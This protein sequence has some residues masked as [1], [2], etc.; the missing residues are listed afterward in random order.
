MDAVTQNQSQ[1]ESLINWLEERAAEPTQ[2]AQKEEPAYVFLQGDELAQTR[3]SHRALLMRAKALAA[4]LQREFSAGDRAIL[5]Y[6]SGLD[7]IVAFFA[8]L[9]AGVIAVPAFPPNARKRDWGRIDAIF[10]NANPAL[11]LTSLC[12]Q[13]GIL[14]W[15]QDQCREK[16]VPVLATDNIDE[17]LVNAWQ[18]PDLNGNSVAFL[19]YS[20]GSTGTPKGVMVSHNNIRHNMKVIHQGFAVNE[21]ERIAS[22]LPIYHDMGLIGS[23]I[24][25]LDVRSSVFFMAPIDALQQ[26][27]RWL[28]VIS[29]F[30]ITASGGP[31]FIYQ[32]CVE[33]VT[34]EQKAQLD[35]SQW[36]LAYNGA[37]PVSH[38]TLQ[39]FA[40]AFAGCGFQVQALTP[41]YGM[42]ETTLMVSS[43][44]RARH[45]QV[46]V[47][48]WSSPEAN[49]TTKADV[50]AALNS[51]EH[52]PALLYSVSSG[53]PN[54][55]LE[56]KI[57]DPD[58]CMECE[59]GQ[60]G[61][62]WVRG[63]SVALG[64]WGQDALTQE[65]FH[66][67]IM[68]QPEDYL[69]TGDLGFMQQGELFVTGR[70]KEVIIIR[71]QNHY[72]QDIEATVA[73]CHDVF[74]GCY[75]AAFSVEVDGAEK[76]VITH[77]ITRAALRNLDEDAVFAE[78]RKAVAEAHQ[79]HIHALVLIRPASLLR[80]TSGKIRRVSMKQAFLESQRGSL[81]GSSHESHSHQEKSAL[82]VA[83]QWLS[84]EAQA[85]T[86][87]EKLGKTTELLHWLRGY[88]ETRIN[89]RLIDERR[90]IAPHIV[91]DMGNQGLMGMHI[92]EA[93]GGLGLSY[94]EASQVYQQLGAIDP[95][96]ALFIGLGNVLGLRPLHKFGSDQIKQRYVSPITQGRML[97]AFAITEPGAGSN[98]LAMHTT[99]VENEDG[100][101]VIT[102]TKVW[103]GSAS[104]A[105]VIN[106][107]AK[108][109]DAKGNALGVTGFAVEQGLPGL[110]IGPEA[111]TMGMRGTCQSR[112][113]LRGVT[114]TP[115]AILGKVGEGMEV[116]Q[117]AMKFGRLVIT[118]ASLGG[119]K[120]C[121][122]L[123]LRYASRRH[124]GTGL[125]LDNPVTQQRLH[126]LKHRI[127]AV[128]SLV[129]RMVTLLDQG[130]DVPIEF[131]AACKMSGPEYFG[132]A[133][134]Q[135]V[136]MLGG[137]GYIE[138][139]IA[140]QLVRDA[141]I[142]RI[143]EGPTETLSM[144][145]GARVN[146]SP[147]D[148][149]SFLSAHFNDEQ[150][151][152][153]PHLNQLMGSVTQLSQSLSSLSDTAFAK[154]LDAE[155]WLH[156]QT[157]KL[158]VIT[159]LLCAT[160]TADSQ[161]HAWLQL[162][163]QHCLHAAQG[164]LKL[165]DV[166]SA[167]A[168]LAWGETCQQAIG[169]I[170][171]QAPGEDHALDPY[172]QRE[173]TVV[174]GQYVHAHANS[175]SSVLNAYPLGG[176]QAVTQSTAD[177]D[178]PQGDISTHESQSDI[179]I[180][181]SQSENPVRTW[182]QNWVA[183]RL[184]VP[185]SQVSATD[186][187]ASFGLDSVDAAVL[188]QDLST[189]FNIPVKADLAWVYPNIEL[190]S[191][192]LNRL[193]STSNTAPS[194]APQA[195]EEWLEGEI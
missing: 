177:A 93:E 73:K 152:S 26:P 60:T 135:L 173:A 163:Y 75:G 195:E 190:A 68:G 105:S 43:C 38:E 162:E 82:K 94:Q 70:K 131:Y 12:H 158:A 136:Q 115:A 112:V 127:H 63:E 188:T 52:N 53:S 144:Y 111:L 137:R 16:R 194:T 191:A 141:R 13:Q 80:T 155:R 167:D 3:L 157:G 66:A 34:D 110:E 178:A 123:M 18:R 159:T 140:P 17:T 32:H 147:E 91:L 49:S 36:K 98:P 149:F 142:L 114:V 187:F 156:D 165:G 128:E 139:N 116:A 58:T 122:Q 48:D 25:P 78:V 170:E 171:Q 153:K 6:P 31:N 124:V 168:L 146:K 2:A 92:P 148:Y 189:E 125:L 21:G 61:E 71:G 134:D 51:N 59:S 113:E 74:K 54:E 28:K 30:N 81:K 95:S 164:F 46:R 117:D 57:V 106:V 185:V 181:E 14:D 119:M 77:E 133:A 67:N 40:R 11:V 160:P 161:T 37:E 39:R 5:L 62:I 97:A 96:L 85:Q 56:L 118:T 121:A 182:M 172:L 79:L 4:Q 44:P 120:R 154:P 64:Y 29:D 9:Y 193:L 107:F 55:E 20:S 23:V 132:E 174:N 42:A 192:Q 88:A 22:W 151:T 45:Y 143:F 179:S 166:S 184:H 183:T 84:T 86:P 69:R 7:Y 102:G 99:A 47:S 129:N 175:S 24:K 104:W 90:S 103:S 87:N 41:C 180:H 109:Y 10:E 145:F 186:D 76:L 169:D 176:E 101:F 19:Q 35:L 65:V 8:C 126:S 138:N 72:P 83:Y 50:N 33:R 1:S 108:T 100:H 89:S 130:I 150:R 15:Q 27:F